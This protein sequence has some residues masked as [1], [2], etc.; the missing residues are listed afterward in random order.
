MTLKHLK[1][2][3]DKNII[4]YDRRSGT[5]RITCS[6]NT[7]PAQL[8]RKIRKLYIEKQKIKDTEKLRQLSLKRN[9][10]LQETLRNPP[11][12]FDTDLKDNN[13]ELDID[14]NEDEEEKTEK[15]IDGS[16]DF[17]VQKWLNMNL[18]KLPRTQY[19]NIGRDTIIIL[20][21]GFYKMYYEQGTDLL[22]LKKEAEKTKYRESERGYPYGGYRGYGGYGRNQRHDQHKTDRAKL[23]KK[24]TKKRRD[25]A[26]HDRDID[27]DDSLV[28][29]VEI[30]Y[31]IVN[32]D[33]MQR[34]AMNNVK[35]YHHN[36][37]YTF[38]DFEKDGDKYKKYDRMKVEVVNE[39]TLYAMSQMIKYKNVKNP[40]ALNFASPKNPGI[41]KFVLKMCVM[42]T[43]MIFTQKLCGKLM[44]FVVNRLW[45]FTGKF[46]SGGDIMSKWWIISNIKEI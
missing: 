41:Y 7:K 36:D 19:R 21:R 9:K 20:K 1:I 31:K 3:E 13:D 10:K 35:L 37:D 14:L 6:G 5:D 34:K 39:T 28:S 18:D 33:E 23:I 46:S 29:K 44:H 2:K 25:R 16:I 26:G 40:M 17:V 4:L 42:L 24:L 32:I 30:K 15:M 27:F 43:L 8:W 45:I 12:L 22:K 38:I 11:N